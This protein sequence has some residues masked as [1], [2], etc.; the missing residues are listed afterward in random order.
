MLVNVMI[1]ISFWKTKHDVLQ[2]WSPASNRWWTHSTT[3]WHRELVSRLPI[4]QLQRQ[5]QRLRWQAASSP[6]SHA[7]VQLHRQDDL[8]PVRVE[9]VAAKISMLWRKTWNWKPTIFRTTEIGWS[10]SGSLQCFCVLFC[11]RSGLAI[12][13]QPR[14]SLAN[15]DSNRWSGLFSTLSTEWFCE[16]FVC[17]AVREERGVGVFPWQQCFGSVWQSEICWE[18]SW[19]GSCSRSF[20]LKQS[21]SYLG[22]DRESQ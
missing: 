20:W 2:T 17:Q 1:K 14:A 18:H 10:F 6:Q 5:H 9:E 8:R 12:A 19:V 15:P 7:Q 13:W 3:Y 16:P 11:I 21:K 4:G 22:H